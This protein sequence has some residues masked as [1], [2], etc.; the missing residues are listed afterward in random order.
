MCFII[1]T[2]IATVRLSK[3]VAFTVLINLQKSLLCYVI[4]W[5]A[6]LEQL[7]FTNRCG[8][9]FDNNRNKYLYTLY[10]WLCSTKSVDRLLS[11]IFSSV[12]IYVCTHH[13]MHAKIF[14]FSPRAYD[15]IIWAT[16]LSTALVCL[17]YLHLRLPKWVPVSVAQTSSL[18]LHCFAV[19]HDRPVFPQSL[20]LQ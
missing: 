6:T 9:Q 16:L 10:G 5:A 13:N 15:H 2:F 7:L 11:V 19:C 3:P 14:L 17:W 20:N 4:L 12:T 8:M 1:V 18:F